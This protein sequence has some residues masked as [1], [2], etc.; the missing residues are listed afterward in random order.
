[1]KTT[2]TAKITNTSVARPANSQSLRDINA[3]AK[4]IDKPTL[5]NTSIAESATWNLNKWVKLLRMITPVNKHHTNVGNWMWVPFVKPS[6][7]WPMSK[8]KESIAMVSMIER[9]FTLRL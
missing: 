6:K 7:Y 5:P 3:I 8:H 1:M 4:K 9:A 2:W